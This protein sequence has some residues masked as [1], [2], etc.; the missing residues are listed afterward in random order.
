MRKR[1]STTFKKKD[2][3]ADPKTDT[4]A[5]S[6]KVSSPPWKPPALEEPVP[7]KALPLLG[8]N[9]SIMKAK[10]LMSLIT[11]VLVDKFCYD[12]QHKKLIK[13][14]FTEFL[15]RLGVDNES[16]FAMLNKEKLWFH[17]LI[18]VA[19]SQVTLPVVRLLSQMADY[20]GTV[21]RRSKY[22]MPSVQYKSLARYV[23]E[24]TDHPG[25]NDAC[26]S[27]S[28]II[29]GHHLSSDDKLPGFKIPKFEG[30]TLTGDVFLKKIRD[31]FKSA[32]Q[33]L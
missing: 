31:T 26:G 13:E 9:I 29:L 14:Q 19:N 18:H 22:L 7:R 8:A 2:A 4:A 24:G 16:T 20:T 6:S 11:T 17:N 15:P 1:R 3:K 10:D 30:D 5:A 27:D 12:R 21:L 23:L 32:G 28:S 25:I 33:A